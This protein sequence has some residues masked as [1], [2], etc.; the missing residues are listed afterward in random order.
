[1]D[2]FYGGKSG[3]SFVLR[4]R[5]DSIDDMI[6]A[7]KRGDS[8]RDIWYN[9]FCIIDT[10]NKNDLDNGKIYQRGLDYTN[11][12]GGA[13]YKGQIVGPESGTPFM[14]L[15]TLEEVEYQSTRAIPEDWNRVYP[16]GYNTDGE[17]HVIG[18]KTSIDEGEEGKPIAIFPFSKAHDTSLVPGKENDGTFNDEIRWTWAN[19]RTPDGHR[20]SWYYVGFEFVY[21]VFEMDTHAVSQYNSSGNYQADTTTVRRSDDKSHPF[22]SSWD[23]G[24]PKGIKGD[25]IRNLRVITPT[26][27]DTIYAPSAIKVNASTGLVSL[28]AA[29]YTGQADDIAASRKIL[30][31]DM[32]Y[33]DNQI[34]PKPVM[35]YV[36]D[37][38]KIDNI[39]LAND[40]TLTVDFSHDNNTVFSR[41]IKWITSTTL[42]PDTGV[43]VV[44]YNNG[45][46][47]F[48]TTLD[49]IKQIELDSDGTLHFWHTK[50][51]R[52]ESYNNAIKWVTSVE[53]NP[54]T[55]LFTMNFNYGSP[56][57]RQLDWV[58]DIYI[59]EDTGEITLHHVNAAIGEDGEVTLP[60]KLKLITSAAVSSDGVVTLYTNTGNSI[61]LKQ[62]G[63]DADYHIKIIENVLLNT[64]LVDDKRI[65]VKYNTERT[66][67]YIG[68]PIN[69]VYDMVV[70]PEDFHLLVLFNDPT[71]RATAGDLDSS[72]KDKNGITW[73]QNVTGSDGIQTA[74]GIYW[75]DYGTIKDQAGVLI[76]FNLTQAD[77]GEGADILNY[78]NEHYPNGLT[79]GATKQK[80]V[81][82]SPTVDDSKDFYAFDY[83]SY[84]WFYLGT[85]SDTGSRDVMLR[86]QGQI[87]DTDLRNLNS[88][89]LLFKI[90]QTSGL[91]TDPIPQFWSRDYSAWQ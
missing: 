66:N 44:N 69:F 67:T 5:F 63:S 86:T 81:T 3:L 24:I 83:N 30:V 38:N 28:G 22:F 15:N 72:G 36:G 91:K 7:F 23:F 8:Y 56:L 62:Q 88:N 16:T 10:P 45:D 70:R 51:N 60:A 32:Y 25:A 42:S 37:F 65:Q 84:T 41:K 33:Y 79:E 49:W 82:F 89:G 85:I 75:R 64:A 2:S 71:H 80:I 11:D 73:V 61:K 90:L 14:Q 54:T 34:N 9:E 29:G 77:I 18:Y 21:P 19:I 27:S 47:A 31:F 46:P 78:L 52:D 1:L 12:M 17:G 43:F 57:T 13:V 58:D 55:G 74:N 35:V 68:D 40:G 76:G 6:Q 53:L 50:N 48:T 4:G 39:T 20:N 59:D 26:S 87:S